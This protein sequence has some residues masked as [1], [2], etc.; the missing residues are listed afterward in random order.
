MAAKIDKAAVEALQGQ[1]NT[2][3]AQLN[4][5]GVIGPK[6]RGALLQYQKDS[7]LPQTG[8]VDDAT[9]ASLT[10]PPTGPNMRPPPE[11]LGTG[12]PNTG[13][14]PIPQQRPPPE[15]LGSGNTN[16]LPRL[17]QNIQASAPEP[18]PS[19]VLAGPPPGAVGPR[20]GFGVSAAQ[21]ASGP[22][23]NDSLV[24][25]AQDD[26]RARTGNQSATIAPGTS[27]D[28]M[29]RLGMASGSRTTEGMQRGLAS[30]D[31]GGMG[32]HAFP[33]Q[34]NPMPP[35]AAPPAPA[36][37][38][39]QATPPPA[40]P[41]A[42]PMPG[43]P[44]PLNATPRLAPKP[45]QAGM[46]LPGLPPTDNPVK[47]FIT[48]PAQAAGGGIQGM[49]GQLMQMLGMGGQPSAPQPGGR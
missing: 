26:V 20:K 14:P 47:A 5:D 24:R 39:A 10:A 46:G 42:P 3:G 34:N 44:S 48:D 41:S 1:L 9:M 16:V 28:Q 32:L 49:I 17:R 25:G 30:L 4:I 7:G 27:W 38:V 23:G 21:E 15:V 13:V 29:Q 40:A 37:Q 8:M 35:P 19:D 2:R 12:K 43:A 11:Q 36:P 45:L 33:P 22:R 31:Q 18:P 6:T